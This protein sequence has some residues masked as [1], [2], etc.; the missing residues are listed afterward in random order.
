MH[1][2][3]SKPPEKVIVTKNGQKINSF[4][5]QK[6]SSNIDWQ[7][8]DSFGEEW[9][10]FNAFS[11]DQLK[12]IGQDYFDLLDQTSISKHSTALDVGCGTGRWSR[13]LSSKVKFIECVDPSKA[14]L[15][16]QNYLSDKSNTRVTMAEVSA[17]PFEDE[18]F[19]L[20]FSLGVLHHIP[21]TQKAMQA[22]VDKVKKGGYFL[23]YLYYDFNERGWLFKFLFK[24]STVLRKVISGLPGG[25]KKLVCDVIALFIYMPFVALSGAV[26]LIF[27]LEASKK[28]PLNFYLG[29]SFTIIRN[30]ALDRFGTPLEQR[31]SKQQIT[32][33]MQQ[34]GLKNIRFS[35][36]QPYWHAIAEK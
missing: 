34:C 3:Y 9:Q 10:K 14:A 8:V 5:D 29:K 12:K 21:D 22:C 30:D 23:V 7:T 13:F 1:V 18:S 16:A 6:K 26:K 24:L 31:F 15:V 25:L 19:D 35:D 28:I 36:R 4:I 17:L 11:E 20:V 27:G 32:E 33:M 2:E